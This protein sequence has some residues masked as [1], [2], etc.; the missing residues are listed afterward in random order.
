MHKE[1]DSILK[2]TKIVARRR[3]KRLR[4]LF[5][6][7]AV[8]VFLVVLPILIVR[9]P[10][11]SIKT[12]NVTGAQTIDSNAV[13]DLVKQDLSG[14]YLRFLPR[15]TFLT[16]FKSSLRSHILN[17]FPIAL[18]AK[19]SFHTPNT[20][21]VEIKERQPFALWC[22]GTDYKNC[23]FADNTGFVYN[24]APEF[25]SPVYI[26]FRNGISA[27][28]PIGQTITDGE[29]LKRIN[30][31]ISN[32]SVLGLKTQEVLFQ[33]NEDVNFNLTHGSLYVSLRG[34]DKLTFNN[35]SSLLL[36]SKTDLRDGSGGIKNSYID[37]RFG[38]KLFY[39]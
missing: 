26:V 27:D 11:L 1:K 16:A 29:T 8:I 24:N 22:A 35:L 19:L 39:K 23:F 28:N 21:L 34:D 14:T 6:S 37:L 17:T 30:D 9:I 3:Q 5:I 18:D 38:N 7:L 2:S 12:I 20:L 36:N 25:S 15:A 33:Q 13:S 32:F 4:I 31:L 10:F